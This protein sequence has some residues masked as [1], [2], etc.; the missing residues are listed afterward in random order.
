Q[1]AVWQRI[2]R[3][4]ERIDRLERGLEGRDAFRAYAR[5]ILRRPFG[6]LGW[7]A[8]PSESDDDRIMRSS[9]IT[10]LGNLG[11]AE[12]AAEAR[13]RFEA[14]LSRPSSLDPNLR[15]A[16]VHVVGRTAD[17]R[18]WDALHSLARAAASAR[19]QM[20]Y[21]MAMARASNPQLIEQTL[22]L[23]LGNELSPERASEMILIVA[24]GEHP[25]L[26]LSFV[27]A[28]F[29]AFAARRSPEFRHFFMSNLM[30]NFAE[31]SYAR[32]LAQFRPVHETSG[33]RIEALRA[34][35]AIMEAADF[36]AKL[37]PLIDSWVRSHPRA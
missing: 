23:T 2:I 24:A 14:F 33:G 18:I 29:A 1:R 9:L 34:E 8:R 27:R 3:V 20:L 28:N 6:R 36:R 15:D 12:V 37:L 16:V 35:A 5:A 30:A 10:A 21:Y 32:E 26:A 31:P 11:D 4:L 19:D 22:Q 7:E 25:E 13:S 17:R